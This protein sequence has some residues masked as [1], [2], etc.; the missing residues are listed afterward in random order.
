MQILLYAFSGK[1]ADPELYL[2]NTFPEGP[3]E[4]LDY[5]EEK[6][7]PA[8]NE[9][10]KAYLNAHNTNIPENSNLCSL[11]NIL[12]KEED[13]DGA[14]FTWYARY[15]DE[16][17]LE[18]IHIVDLLPGDMS[19]SEIL[20]E[21]DEWAKRMRE[22][23]KLSFNQG[24]MPVG[25]TMEFSSTLSYTTSYLG[26]ATPQAERYLTQNRNQPGTYEGEVENRY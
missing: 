22:S 9:V 4:D 11:L 16:V 13:R 1:D 5:V 7:Y 2:S 8:I 26:G 15:E 17:C 12:D 6:L 19:L 20:T 21:F 23:I 18:P 25:H 24:Y 14:C 3:K 10:I